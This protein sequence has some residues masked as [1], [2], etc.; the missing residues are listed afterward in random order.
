MNK[1]I[2]HVLWDLDG[3]LINSEK[4]HEDAAWLVFDELGIPLINKQIPRG[5]ENRSGFEHVTG[6]DTQEHEACKLFNVWDK[7]VVE[8]AMAEISHKHAITQSIELVKYFHKLGISQSIVS[9]SY[10]NF[11]EQSIEKIGIREYIDKIF[12]RDMAKHAK[13]DPELYIQAINY[14]QCNIENTLAFEDSG[15]GITAAKAANLDV[16]GIDHESSKHNPKLTL[17]TDTYNWLEQLDK[18]YFFTK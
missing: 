1:I 9:N 16:V 6:L 8:K 4:I 5:I 2:T 7:L 10:A 11:V 12:T 15:T 14:Y 17:Y 18:Y 13:P 3:T